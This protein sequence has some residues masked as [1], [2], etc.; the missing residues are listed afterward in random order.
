MR[1]EIVLVLAPEEA[2]PATVFAGGGPAGDEA[3]RAVVGALLAA[4]RPTKEAARL[5]ATLTGMPQREAYALA[6]AV[7]SARS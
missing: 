3:V 5:V 2:R 6:V 4:G 7:R 1:G